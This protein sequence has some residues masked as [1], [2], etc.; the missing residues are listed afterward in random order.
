MVNAGLIEIILREQDDP[1]CSTTRQIR[2]IYNNRSGEDPIL[3]NSD[4]DKEFQSFLLKA[5]QAFP[6]PVDDDD[7]EEDKP[8]S[9]TVKL[10]D[11]DD[12]ST[13]S[14]KKQKN[15]VKAMKNQVMRISHQ[16]H[17]Q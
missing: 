9:Y 7:D 17:H 4:L 13:P 14:M 11:S 3:Q 8:I 10:K 16:Q 15:K 12:N 5:L 2:D 1:G 6:R